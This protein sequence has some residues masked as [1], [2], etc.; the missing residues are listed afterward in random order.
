M[1]MTLFLENKKT[2]WTQKQFIL[3]YITVIGGYYGTNNTADTV[4][5]VPFSG[6]CQESTQILLFFPFILQK[7]NTIET[8]K[9]Q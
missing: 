4:F 7:R 6:H 1:I 3:F 9:E 8:E 5:S 2:Y